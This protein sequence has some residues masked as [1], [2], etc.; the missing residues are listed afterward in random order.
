MTLQFKYADTYI[1]IRYMQ[2]INNYFSLDILQPKV[3]IIYIK[4]GKAGPE[5]S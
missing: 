2:L 3:I 1:I 5:G 4:I